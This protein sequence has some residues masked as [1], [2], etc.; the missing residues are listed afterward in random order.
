MVGKNGKPTQF[1]EDLNH[2]VNQ[3]LNYY[4]VEISLPEPIRKPQS[5][6]L[7]LAGDRQPP[8]EKLQLIYPALL[9]PCQ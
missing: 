1:E 4:R 5:C 6:R 7:R 8:I 9:M 3:I 2:Q